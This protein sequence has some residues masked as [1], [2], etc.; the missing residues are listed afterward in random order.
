M[1]NDTPAS[2]SKILRTVELDIE[3]DRDLRTL[4]FWEGRTKGDIMRDAIAAY[5]AAEF[6]TAGAAEIGPEAREA[7]I[8]RRLGMAFPDGDQP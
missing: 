1:S 3:I 2:G 7:Y 5:V 8:A 4:S 6:G